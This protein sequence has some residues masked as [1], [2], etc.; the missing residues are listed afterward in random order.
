MANLI[1]LNVPVLFAVQHDRSFAATLLTLQQVDHT[2]VILTLRLEGEAALAI[3][4]A[5]YFNNAVSGRVRP[6]VAGFDEHK[7][8]LFELALRQN[9]LAAYP[10]YTAADYAAMLRGDQPMRTPLLVES[11]WNTLMV[12]QETLLDASIGGGVIKYGYK[13]RWTEPE[14]DIERIR[15]RGP[16]SEVMIQ[17]FIENSWPVQLAADGETLILDL[18]VTGKNFRGYLIA[19]DADTVASVVMEYLA[20]V[21][22]ERLSLLSAWIAASQAAVAPGFFEYAA[23]SAHVSYHCLI[24][25][26]P[27]TLDRAVIEGLVN[28]ALTVMAQHAPAVD[29]VI[30]APLS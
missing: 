25:V 17:A 18:T 14:N 4:A 13:T 30:A 8:L 7:P 23:Q 10:G 3:E 27:E 26:P 5:G 16:V 24:Q 6:P 2:K 28:L 15:R 11:A 22:S 9:E 20:E 29:E 19:D 21:P 12:W 1:E